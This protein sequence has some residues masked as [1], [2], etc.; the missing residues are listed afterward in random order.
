[1]YKDS[2]YTKRKKRRLLLIAIAV[3]S[4]FFVVSILLILFGPH[5]R[6]GIEEVPILSELK[7]VESRA[8]E[9]AEWIKENWRE[10]IRL[11]FS[12]ILP[13]NF[14]RGE[15]LCSIGSTSVSKGIEG[16]GLPTCFSVIDKAE[17]LVSWSLKKGRF[18]KE[19]PFNVL[20]LGPAYNAPMI[21]YKV[22]DSYT[23]IY[24]W[25]GDPMAEWLYL[26]F[27]NRTSDY[28]L[29]MFMYRPM[30]EAWWIPNAWYAHELR[31]ERKVNLLPPIEFYEKLHKPYEEANE[32]KLIYHT[33]W[34]LIVKIYF[35]PNSPLLNTT[36]ERF[37]QV[38]SSLYAKY[39]VSKIHLPYYELEHEFLYPIFSSLG[40]NVNVTNLIISF[41]EAAPW[42]I[43]HNVEGDEG[44]I[45]W[46]YMY[47]NSSGIE[48]FFIRERIF[49]EYLNISK[50]YDS[51][52][53][54][55]RNLGKI[56]YPTGS[57]FKVEIYYKPRGGKLQVMYVGKIRLINSFKPKDL[58]PIAID[59][60]L[61][62]YKGL[63]IFIIVSSP[64]K[65]IDTIAFILK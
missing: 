6:K 20:E 51:M 44:L 41:I 59:I 27:F 3:T 22:S 34:N 17:K 24:T 36:K 25:S 1:M 31:I 55:L 64:T 15:S 54:Y 32:V 58:I 45:L 11:S 18:P 57:E 62:P 47:F 29:E 2:A 23:L 28:L 19:Y 48:K 35:S 56:T 50:D 30:W 33:Y 13:Y 53:I 49:I 7:Y 42:N 4:L 14:Y 9:V 12:V 46:G 39:K 16:G 5:V 8:F 21:Y 37:L 38:V 61:K 63:V 52:T 60:D 40:L 26:A 43:L 10:A 65:T